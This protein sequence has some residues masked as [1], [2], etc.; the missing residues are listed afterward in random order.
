MLYIHNFELHIYA[1][2]LLFVGQDSAV[3][4]ATRYGLGGPRIESQWGRDIRTRPE[5]P[6][7]PPSLLYN[8]YRIF[9]GGKAAEAWR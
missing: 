2:N 7:D 4:I 3:A 1:D 5:R 8:G 9:P 6:W